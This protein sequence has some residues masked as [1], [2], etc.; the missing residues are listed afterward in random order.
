M[1]GQHLRQ[2]EE[3]A[4]SETWKWMQRVSLKREAERLIVAAQ[5]QAL[6]TNYWKARIEKSSNDPKCRLCRENDETVNH[7]VSEC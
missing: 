2:T 3:E 6:R 5:D 7:L 1:N 4:A